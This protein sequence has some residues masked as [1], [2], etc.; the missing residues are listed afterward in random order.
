MCKLYTTAP[1]DY[2]SSHTQTID[3]LVAIDPV[4]DVPVRLISTPKK[5]KRWQYNRYRSGNYLVL[6]QSELEF[7]IRAGA[8]IRPVFS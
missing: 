5:V 4:H 7:L 3:E 2:D 8:L 1:K 6:D